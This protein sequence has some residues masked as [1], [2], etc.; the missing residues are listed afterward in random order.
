MSCYLLES[1]DAHVAHG[2]EVLVSSGKRHKIPNVAK[3]LTETFLTAVLN[4][5]DDAE[6][7]WSA[8]D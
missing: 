5:H 2:L 6:R 4:R 7:I 3:P 8:L 1:I